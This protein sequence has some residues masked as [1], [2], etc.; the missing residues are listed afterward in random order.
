MQI[1]AFF[2]FCSRFPRVCFLYVYPEKLSSDLR[3]PERGGVSFYAM[4]KGDL[5]YCV[6]P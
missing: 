4:D 3:G 1:A 2:H 5:L 6:R